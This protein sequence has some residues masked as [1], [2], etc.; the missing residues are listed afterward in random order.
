M[1]F[2][3]QLFYHWYGI[4]RK[5]YYITHSKCLRVKNTLLGIS[6]QYILE[7]EWGGGRLSMKAFEETGEG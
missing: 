2:S 4:N 5:I 3:N 7:Q 1:V 6:R